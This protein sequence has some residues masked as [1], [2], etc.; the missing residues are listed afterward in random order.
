MSKEA[1]NGL[2]LVAAVG[3]P[4]GRL[5]AASRGDFR[6]LADDQRRRDDVEVELQAIRHSQHS[7]VLS[8]DDILA[9]VLALSAAA[10]VAC[11]RRAA[12]IAG[13]TCF[14]QSL[15]SI[16]HKMHVYVMT[17]IH[18][19]RSQRRMKW[20]GL[21]EGFALPA[22][23]PIFTLGISGEAGFPLDTSPNPHA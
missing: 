9:F 13:A 17:D 1:T 10:Q 7:S 6:L 15:A 12:R 5:F 4:P 16:L 20:A 21:R 8:P 3:V 14:E 22:P 23:L 19:L 2:P 18:A 11:P